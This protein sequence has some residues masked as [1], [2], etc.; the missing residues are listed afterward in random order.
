M[1]WKITTPAMPISAATTAVA[2]T[3]P[4]YGPAARPARG[5]AAGAVGS[6]G[7]GAGVVAYAGGATAGGAAATGAGC[8][9]GAAAGG[10]GGGSNLPAAGMRV[11]G[12]WS[13]GTDMWAPR[14][15]VPGS[16][17]GTVAPARRRHPGQ[18]SER[19]ARQPD[20]REESPEGIMS[21]R[22]NR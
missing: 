6:A 19:G 7:E 20:E 18:R 14:A 10:A 15:R 13:G 2:T 22:W 21:T 1:F 4:Q 5:G 3:P 12:G 16:H 9:G 8:A 11:V 17:G